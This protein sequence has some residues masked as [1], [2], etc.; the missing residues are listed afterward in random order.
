MDCIFCKIIAGE[1]PSSRV[2][3]NDTVYAFDDIKPMAPC[4]VLLIPKKHIASVDELRAEDAHLMGD[5]FMAVKEIARIK[6]VEA[7]GYRVL[8]NNGHAAGQEVFHLHLHILGGLKSMGPMLS[9]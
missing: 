5:L 1:I 8:L 7:E 6:G 2:Y 9:V 4:H 3:E